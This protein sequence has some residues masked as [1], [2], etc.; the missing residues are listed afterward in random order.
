MEPG[1]VRA[2]AHMWRPLAMVVSIAASTLLVGGLVYLLTGGALRGLPQEVR[3]AVWWVV[4][5]V[6]AVPGILYVGL[7]KVGVV[8]PL[9]GRE[10]FV[11]SNPCLWAVCVVFYAGIIY[12]CWTL[13]MNRRRARKGRVVG[14]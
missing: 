13:A 2:R 7:S 11:E 14:G 8:P 1:D 9:V 4:I 10:S 3:E 5:A 6:L 12:C